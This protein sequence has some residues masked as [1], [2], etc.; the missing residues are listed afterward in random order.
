VFAGNGDREHARDGAA[1]DEQPQPVA[2]TV[3]ERGAVAKRTSVRSAAR[4]R[5]SR[6]SSAP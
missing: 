3:R 4:S 1:G 2:R 5:R 6:L